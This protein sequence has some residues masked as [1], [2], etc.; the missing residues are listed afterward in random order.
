MSKE[1]IDPE[2]ID[3]A[4][5]ITGVINDRL[6]QIAE[7][8]T[9]ALPDN[10]PFVLI[11]APFVEPDMPAYAKEMVFGVSSE[12]QPKIQAMTR[13]FLEVCVPDG[14]RRQDPQ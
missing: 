9:K 8:L 6:G 10:V 11:V 4:R 14:T 2:F 5:Q 7:I 13:K 3:Q 1:T 12:K